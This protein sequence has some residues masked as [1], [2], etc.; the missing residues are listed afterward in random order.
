MDILPEISATFLKNVISYT[1]WIGLFLTV[2]ILSV[3][4][5]Y[6]RV[7][8]PNALITEGWRKWLADRL[9]WFATLGY[10]GTIGIIVISLTCGLVIAKVEDILVQYQTTNLIETDKP[11]TK[12]ELTQ[13]VRQSLAEAQIFTSLTPQILMEMMETNVREAAFS[14]VGLQVHVRGK[15]YRIDISSRMPLKQPPVAPKFSILVEVV[16]G[17]DHEDY[18]EKTVY[19]YVDST[20]EKETR[21]FV[22]LK[23]GHH[24]VATGI[25]QEIERDSMTVI[26]GRIVSVKRSQQN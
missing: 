20:N 13:N 8:A 18:P 23:E 14:Q 9:E 7:Y 22:R 26:D 12:R 1:V 19:L 17:W 15:V 11:D 3:E 16:V 10:K 25:I 24:I 2:F 21:K 6:Q 5:L 4:L